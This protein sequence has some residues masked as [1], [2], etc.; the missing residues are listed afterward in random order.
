[1]IA[2]PQ[3]SLEAAAEVARARPASTPLI[4][5]DALEGEAREVGKLMAGIALS[6]VQHGQPAAG[7]P[8]CCS[9]AARPR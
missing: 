7:R 5:G 2:T 3:M 8:A 4:L 6:V 9:R 1:M